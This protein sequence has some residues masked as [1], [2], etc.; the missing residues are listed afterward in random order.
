MKPPPLLLL[1]LLGRPCVVTKPHDEITLY[2]KLE[3]NFTPEKPTIRVREWEMGQLGTVERERERDERKSS[4]AGWYYLEATWVVSVYVVFR[5]AAAV[6][7]GEV[8][9]N[10]CLRF[11]IAH[12]DGESNSTAY[13]SYFDLT[14]T[15]THNCY[16]CCTAANAAS[17]SWADARTSS[18][19]SPW[20][21]IITVVVVIIFIIARVSLYLS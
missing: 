17:H 3:T 20:R 2:W 9:V 10:A 7:G 12:E 21:K 19:S 4:A 14:H 6:A 18:P 8:K 13:T 1:V 5:A 15:H 16:Y 11:F